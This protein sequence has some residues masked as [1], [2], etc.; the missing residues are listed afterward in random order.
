[1]TAQ[2]TWVSF[3]F[4][5]KILKLNSGYGCTTL[6]ILKTTEFVHLFKRVNLCLY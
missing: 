1:M 6:N 4:D 2:W 5:K 3:G